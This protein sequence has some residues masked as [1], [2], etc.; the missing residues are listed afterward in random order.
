[1][2]KTNEKL[3]EKL[4]EEGLITSE[5]VK[6][7]FL[8]VD[9]KDFVPKQM[10]DY[11]YLDRPIH[12][13]EGQTISAPHMVA[14][15]TEHLN[16]ERNHKVM[17]IG[18][19]SGYQ[20]AILSKIT[21]NG[22][23][24]T[25]E[26]KKSLFKKLMNQMSS[27]SNVVLHRGDGSQGLVEEAPF[28]RIISTCGVPDIPFPWEKQLKKQGIILAPVGSK[29]HQRLK[30]YEKRKDSLLEEDLGVPCVFVPSIGKYGFK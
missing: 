21:Y 6:R 18:T 9:R 30:K 20:A 12:I 2:A 4:S 1:M 8:E 24:H 11:A 28:D 23:I 26:V 14:V 10:N 17:E 22:E 19:G 16:L 29:F 5:K 13:G 15:M 7:A 27:Y 25:I 3:V